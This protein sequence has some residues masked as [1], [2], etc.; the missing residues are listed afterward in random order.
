MVEETKL[1]GENHKPVASHWQTLSHNVVSSTPRL[2][3]VRTH[4]TRC[5]KHWL[6]QKRKQ[7]KR[8]N[9]DIQSTTQK[10]YFKDNLLVNLILITACYINVLHVYH[11]QTWWH[12][13]LCFINYNP[14]SSPKA[15]VEDL[16]KHKYK[17]KFVY[18]N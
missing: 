2:S 17:H 13:F 5:D 15:A 1:P 14:S 4:N 11:E 12:V 8:A 9:N 10:K 18:C 16:I 6:W 7:G 3:C